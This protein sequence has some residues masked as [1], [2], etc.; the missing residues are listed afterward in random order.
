[1]GIFQ[2]NETFL[3]VEEKNNMFCGNELY[4]DYIGRKIN[5]ITYSFDLVSYINAYVPYHRIEIDLENE[6]KIV[7]KDLEFYERKDGMCIVKLDLWLSAKYRNSLLRM[8]L[9][10]ELSP[11]A[12]LELTNPMAS[13]KESEKEEYARKILIERGIIAEND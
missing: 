7:L 8:A 4:S 5:S 6:A 9:D 13:M 3:S 2:D 10:E 11:D 12:M 1:M